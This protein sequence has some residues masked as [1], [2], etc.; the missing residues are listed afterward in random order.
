MIVSTATAN[1]WMSH[2]HPI[3]PVGLLRSHGNWLVT[4]LV[5]ASFFATA[6]ART[7]E[8]AAAQSAGFR[9]FS[10]TYP[11]ADEER[12]R[13]VFL[14]YPSSKDAQRHDYRGQIGF[15][16]VDAEVAQGSHPLILFS[17]GFLGTGDQIIFL[18]EAFA[19]RGYIVA[20][21]NHADSL[22]QKRSKPIEPPKFADA[23]TW[24][25]QKFRDRQEDLV[26]LLEHLLSLHRQKDSFL[27]EHLNVEQIGACGHSLGGYTVLGL[28]GAW[29]SWRDERIKAVLALSPYSM[30]FLTQGT[31]AEIKIPVMIQGGTLDFGITP[32]QTPIYNKLPGPK[33]LLVLKNETHFGW[34]N[35][36]S[37]GK[38]TTEVVKQGNA[39]LITDYGIAFFERH[40]RGGNGPESELLD[41]DNPRLDSYRHAER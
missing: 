21:L 18:M 40:L 25:D 3:R 20:S 17:H 30:P 11:A 29:E 6:P 2:I 16:A 19:R 15:V 33:Y 31:I 8:P 36:I 32:F 37:L 28:A 10:I 9:K 24:T 13:N 38:T 34:T 23:K 1:G 41:Q 39:Q 26:A 7:E 35:L 14:W 27:H 22:F 5:F 12:H 4:L